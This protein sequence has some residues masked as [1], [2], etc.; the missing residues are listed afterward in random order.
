M[1]FFKQC[2]L[3]NCEKVQTAWI[4][5]QYAHVG[6]LVRLKDDDGRWDD[7]WLVCEVG[8]RQSGEYVLEHEQDYK[9]QAD[10]SDITDV[11]TQVAKMVAK[12]KP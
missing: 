4:P 10:A 6:R 1:V 9:T 3:V 5:E 8:M 12:E 7:H 2:R 11:P